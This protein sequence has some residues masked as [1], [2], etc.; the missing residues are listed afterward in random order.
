MAEGARADAGGGG[1]K[2]NMDSEESEK[3]VEAATR[4]PGT[5]DPVS[6]VERFLVGAVGNGDSS[7]EP[8]SQAVVSE[9]VRVLRNDR[10]RA[11]DFASVVGLGAALNEGSL[12]E[13]AYEL[14]R[15][16][17][18]VDEEG[19]L[20]GIVLSWIHVGETRPEDSRVLQV[21]TGSRGF[22]FFMLLDSLP[23]FITQTEI[24]VKLLGLF[25]R[26]VRSTVGDDLGGAEFWNALNALAKQ[27]PESAVQLFHLW[28]AEPLD[29]DSI[30][31]C[32]LI[33]GTLRA[34]GSE[35]TEAL[36]L[37]TRSSLKLEFR[38]VFIRSW[39]TTDRIGTIEDSQFSDILSLAESGSRGDLLEIFNFLRLALPRP[40]RSDVSFS[41]GV[42]WIRENLPSDPEDNLRHQIID[43][44][45]SC[46]ARADRLGT[47]P[48]R[49]IIAATL[50]IPPEFKG[51]WE[52]LGRLLAQLLGRDRSAGLTLLREVSQ[53]D[54]NGVSTRLDDEESWVEFFE[55]LNTVDCEDIVASFL[56]SSDADDRK[57][58][59]SLF[60]RLE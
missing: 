11:I 13:K 12:S 57:M 33:L 7:I 26:N 45:L 21:F 5:E 1:L 50:P 38:R 44:S 14:T 18:K 39:I 52:V 37:L 31:M 27:R 58:G 43:L 16:L 15:K 4:A 36:D 20:L 54:R 34:T 25:L 28:L 9:A 53:A 24:E 40:E 29:D 22:P 2:G 17:I 42:S 19:A 55:V 51:T 47:A 8:P 48:L 10:E 41:H 60:G 23:A 32:A 46:D 3:D 56:S 35:H 59:F 30:S 6:L 49:S